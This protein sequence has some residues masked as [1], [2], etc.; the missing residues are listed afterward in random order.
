MWLISC[1]GSSSWVKHEFPLYRGNLHL[2][3]EPKKQKKQTLFRSHTA[4]SLYCLSVSG[5]HQ[6]NPCTLHK[7]RFIIL[8]PLK[9]ELRVIVWA[10]RLCSSTIFHQQKVVKRTLSLCQYCRH[11]SVWGYQSKVSVAGFSTVSWYVDSDQ[12]SHPVSEM[13]SHCSVVYT[14]LKRQA[15][16]FSKGQLNKVCEH[17]TCVNATYHPNQPK[18]NPNKQKTTPAKTVFWT[19]VKHRKMVDYMWINFVSKVLECKI[20]DDWLV[21]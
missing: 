7:N 20:S 12:R 21:R 4:H 1:Y 5:N 9:S 16:T 10:R 11:G 8:I 2:N 17:K 19:A 3:D 13:K 18:K 6:S 15:D 14:A